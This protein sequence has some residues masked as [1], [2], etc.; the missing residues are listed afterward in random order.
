MTTIKQ[1]F[2]IYSLMVFERISQP[3]MY[4]SF[5]LGIVFFLVPAMNLYH[6]AINLGEYINIS[7]ILLKGKGAFIKVMLIHISYRLT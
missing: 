6:Y 4:I 3:R 7:E 5:A 1:V 2:R